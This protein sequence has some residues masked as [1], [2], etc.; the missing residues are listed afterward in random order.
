MHSN[1]RILSI[2]GG[3]IKGIIPAQLLV[4]LEAKLQQQSGNPDARIGDYFDLIAGTSTG[5]LLACL[6]LA[7]DG[8]GKRPRYTAKELVQLYLRQGRFIFGRTLWQRVSSLNG[9]IDEKYH[10]RMLESVIASKVGDLRLSQLLKPCMITSYSIKKRQTVFFT[11]H[12]SGKGDKH[13]VMVRTVARAT[14]AAPTYFEAAFDDEDGDDAEGYI[15]GGVFANNPAM[16]A[17]VEAHKLVPG[18]LSPANT[19]MLSLGTGQY[20]Q[21]YTHQ[22][23]KDWGIGRWA[24]PLL[25]ILMSSSAET[26]DY[27]LRQ[28]FSAADRHEHYLRI[29]PVLPRGS[30]AMDNVSEHNLKALRNRALEETERQTAVLDRMASMLVRETAAATQ[31]P[32]PLNNDW[33]VAEAAS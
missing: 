32:S 22:Q 10:A 21:S 2:D 29:Q 26:V 14:S 4:A 11:Q 9:I 24:R 13:D 17:Y 7:P 5:G 19:T 25:S 20:K 16:C 31:H 28:L 1:F 30:E 33:L 23:V 8:E 15:D 12:N 18:G 6:L 27:Q 3:G